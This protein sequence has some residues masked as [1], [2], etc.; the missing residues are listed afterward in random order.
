V[1]ADLGSESIHEQAAPV[2]A[3]CD[4]KLERSAAL[5]LHAKPKRVGNDSSSRSRDYNIRSC[6]ISGLRRRTR[7]ML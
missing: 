6:P 1:N 5:D 2:H 3:R 4:A 7:A